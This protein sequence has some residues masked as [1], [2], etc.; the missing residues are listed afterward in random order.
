ME[1]LCLV[2]LYWHWCS[3]VLNFIGI[4]ISLPEPSP[5]LPQ[6]WSGKNVMDHLSKN[7]NPPLTP[8]LIYLSF[9]SHFQFHNALSMTLIFLWAKSYLHSQL[10]QHSKSPLF[11]IAFVNRLFKTAGVLHKS[12]NGLSFLSP[13][14]QNIFKS[15]FYKRPPYL[16]NNKNSSCISFSPKSN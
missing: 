5:W 16:N 8:V 12:W 9:T 14:A 6:I 4:E 11:C 7:Q 13:F 3:S 15:H 2:Q 1:T 10:W